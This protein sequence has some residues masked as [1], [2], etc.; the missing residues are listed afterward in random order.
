MTA[1]SESAL[2]ELKKKIW[3]AAVR[4]YMIEQGWSSIGDMDN[5]S[6]FYADNWDG[7]LPAVD[8]PTGSVRIT[9]LTGASTMGLRQSGQIL[10]GMK[11]V[12]QKGHPSKIT[13]DW[14]YD[15]DV[16]P[17]TSIYKP[18]QDRI[19]G[20]FEGWNHHVPDPDR[21]E[22]LIGHVRGALVAL[23]PIPTGTSIP[24][25]SGG[26]LASQY[27]N[28]DFEATLRTMENWMD[29]A[30]DG[31]NMSAA[32]MRFSEKYA[33]RVRPLLVN[34]Q[35]LAVVLGAA[36]QAE[37]QIW[38]KAREDIMRI[39]DDGVPAFRLS[40]GG[41]IDWGVL[42]ALVDVAVDFLPPE[43]SGPVEGA[44][45]KGTDI[46]ELWN[47]VKPKD[48]GGSDNRKLSFSGSTADEIA[49]NLVKAVND[50][51]TSVFDKEY[52]VV[53][54]LESTLDQ[55]HDRPA[56]DWHINAEPGID[57]KFKAAAKEIRIHSEEL[58]VIGF[59]YCPTIA[60]SWGKAA[61]DLVAADNESTWSRNW[62]LGYGLDGAYSS[63]S[64]VKAQ[65]DAMMTGSGAELVD[66][67]K[68]LAAVGGYFKDTDG[69]A[70]ADLRGVKDDLE[71]GRN[72]YDNS[73]VGVPAPPYETLPNGKRI[74]RMY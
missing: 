54:V 58:K 37:K 4:L 6:G 20:A 17:W 32:V 41:D 39:A 34:H 18:W 21:F 48:D 63:W 35:K 36:L 14:C 51:N 60:A 42:K 57:P 29:P 46:L 49:D 43:I 71:R 50:L 40:G 44:I 5:P 72:G 13:G 16:D 15:Y 73:H 25:G 7:Q 52:A 66:A 1:Y 9:M 61:Q 2:D 11:M 69:W 45:A 12:D 62:R 68:I 10:P 23:T 30:T 70:A 28:V 31:G 67:G 74:P 47:K 65:L 22:T 3:I 55:I 53:Q 38:Q 59:D 19:Y 27:A 26:D 64:Q 8:G 24:D 33:M 56:S